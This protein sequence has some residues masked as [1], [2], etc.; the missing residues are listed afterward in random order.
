M[1]KRSKSSLRSKRGAGTA[2]VLTLFFILLISALVV[3][4]LISMR[5]DRSSTQGYYQSARVQELANG[6]LEEILFD[7]QSEIAAGSRQSNVF[8]VNGQEIFV[9][10]AA[11]ASQPA[12]IG[13]ALGTNGDYATDLDT[14][15]VKLP[16]TLIRVSR[17]NYD[18]NTVFPSSVYDATKTPPAR[19][20]AVSTTNYSANGRT[21]SPKRWN[22]SY[23]LSG[24]TTPPARFTNNA[25]DWIYMTRAGSRI[26]VDADVPSSKAGQDLDNTN[27]IVGRYAYVVY[28]GG[29]LI[30]VNAAGFPST[31]TA[32]NSAVRGK[33]SIIYAALASLPGL[34]AT[35]VD[36]LLKWRSAGSVGTFNATNFLKASTNWMT[37]GFLSATNGDSPFLGR[38]DLIGY[39]TKKV[40]NTQALPLL[41]TFSRYVAAPSLRPTTPSG[42]ALGSQFDYDGKADNVSTN[43]PI[44]NRDLANVR[45]AKNATISHYSDDATA[46]PKSYDATEGDPLLQS[47]FS[48]ARLGWLE[49]Y[50]NPDTGAG[51]SETSNEGK[52]IKACF[53][54]VWGAPGGNGGTSSANGGNNCWNYVGATGDI[55]KPPATIKTL[56][57]VAA[58]GREP[59]FF[60][61]LKAA[62]LTGSL[63]VGPGRAAYNNGTT[64]SGYVNSEYAL[65]MTPVAQFT[66]PFG[67]YCHTLGPASTTPAP[68]R[69][70]DV[71]IMKIGA[72]IIDQ[73]DADSWPTAIYF[74][75]GYPDPGD[76]TKTIQIG[77]NDPAVGAPAGNPILGPVTMI[78]GIENLPYLATIRQL[79]ASLGRPNGSDP[80]LGSD[81]SVKSM[82]GWLQPY[83]WNPHQPP[84]QTST[85]RP[86]KF[87][88]RAYGASMRMV[89]LYDPNPAGNIDDWNTTTEGP[90]KQYQLSTYQGGRSLVVDY[91]QENRNDEVCDIGTL[92]FRDTPATSS[93]YGK[94]FPLLLNMDDATPDHRSYGSPTPNGTA[95]QNIA[96]YNKN[97]IDYSIPNHFLGFSTGETPLSSLGSNYNPFFVL[98]YGT[99]AVPAPNHLWRG[100]ASIVNRPDIATPATTYTLGWRDSGGKFHPYSYIT[101]AF[102]YQGI[103]LQQGVEIQGKTPT[104]PG[105]PVQT[106]FPN[107]KVGYANPEYGAGDTWMLS[108][109]RTERFSLAMRFWSGFRDDITVYSEQSKRGQWYYWLGPPQGEPA[110]SFSRGN[111]FDMFGADKASRFFPGDYVV[112]TGTDAGAFFYR[113]RDGV[114]RPADGFYGNSTS[115]D[116]RMTFISTPTGSTASGDNAAKS[117]GRLPVILDRPFNSVAELGYVFRDQPFKTLD[118]FSDKSADSA[119]LDVF[120]LHDTA[121]VTP[122]GLLPI[123]AGRMNLN[124]T[125][126]TSL[127]ALLKGGSKKDADSGY[128]LQNEVD[129]L[130]SNISSQITTATGFSPL[131]G[132]RDLAPALVSAIRN[133]ATVPAADKANKAYLEAPLRALAEAADFRT[134]NLVIDLIAQTG[135][136]SPNGTK[137]S[138]FTVQAECRVW[139]HVAIDRFTGKVIARQVEPVYE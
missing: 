131:S 76:A 59:D 109:P 95:D 137:A 121:A 118:F 100:G 48:L 136:I 1:K 72:N 75:Y 87:Q 116:G 104:S 138:D 6:A 17:A 112:N 96:F 117:H 81:L 86:T 13:F 88:I 32:T 73:Y 18:S 129:S 49:K 7:F 132:Y 4:L 69:I 68:A 74:K 67:Y 46:L 5:L 111:M 85:T 63:G 12:R 33:S 35:N 110:N 120:C 27:T 105:Y 41:G 37:N 113:D 11:T 44:A 139:L 128:N 9:P 28:D 24:T 10:K 98:D 58:E 66:G 3:A 79:N 114:V 94:A 50:A 56:A 122:K 134:W 22:S 52:A 133:T 19:A 62:I 124:A 39:F 20:S 51:P 107:R 40:G 135:Q 84:P 31:L 108:D 127:K 119:L 130:A 91:Y 71:Q 8:I 101:G 43:A 53:G 23:L 26:V 25:P 65:S 57:E 29:G 15:N 90:V 30:D 78:Y 125:P 16:P 99:P 2:L 126:V 14:N 83:L 89:W 102:A 42:V 60:E 55:S 54:L 64:T 21:I 70:P 61:L 106:G 123:A 38:K 47:R 92:N 36:D 45:M 93:F 115:G 34:N 97:L 82:S 103:K 77:S 80:T